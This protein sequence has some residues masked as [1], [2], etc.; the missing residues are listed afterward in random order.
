MMKNGKNIIALLT[1]FGIKDYFIG[2]MKGVILSIIKNAEIVDITHEIPPQN[3]RSASFVLSA[4]YKNFPE[5]T[6]FTTV[7]DPGVGSN[8]RAILVETENYYF[9]APDNGLLN[10]I[11]DNEKDFRVFELTV[12]KFFNKPVSKTFHGRDIFSPAAAHLSNGVKP[13]EFGAEIKDFI[14]H[15]TE[16]PKRLDEN[17]IEAEIIHADHFGNLITNLKKG[18]LPEKF[19]LEINGKKIEKLQSFFAEAKAGELFMIF[20]SADFLEIAANQNSAK[21]ILKAKVG[22]KIAVNG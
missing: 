11:F 9:I 13:E 10:F 14:F 18:D 6:I 1:D 2:A 22:Q 16:S 7:V 21:R 5:K 19:T 12:D 20:G 8:R 15:K 17:T 3:I 4:C